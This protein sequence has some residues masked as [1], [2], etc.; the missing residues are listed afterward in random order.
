MLVYAN[1]MLDQ[2]AP[3]GTLAVLGAGGLVAAAVV[4]AGARG[5]LLPA[6]AAP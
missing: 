1:G 5:P 6:V 2:L 3:E 4:R